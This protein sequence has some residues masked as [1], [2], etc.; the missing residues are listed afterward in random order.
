MSIAFVVLGRM[1][2]MT[3]PRV[4]ELSVWMGVGGCLCPISINVACIVTACHALI[5]NAASSS[6]TKDSMTALMSFVLL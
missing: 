4:V 6:L 1:V 5:N 3:M 2:H